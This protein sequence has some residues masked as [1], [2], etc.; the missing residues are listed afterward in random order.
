MTPRLLALDLVLTGFLALTGYAVWQYGYLGFFELAFANAATT[1]MFV[2]LAIA[3]VLVAVWMWHDARET[4]VPG[5][6]YLVVGLFLGAAGPLAYLM[7]R[8]WRSR[9][10]VTAPAAA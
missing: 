7:H 3:L 9:R 6:P 10:R 4:G 8:E 5:V 1:L 2:D